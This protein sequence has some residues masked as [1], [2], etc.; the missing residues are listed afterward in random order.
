MGK[1]MDFV[2]AARAIDKVGDEIDRVRDE[3][4]SLGPPEETIDKARAAL[5]ALKERVAELEEAVAGRRAADSAVRTALEILV[6]VVGHND[7]TD[8]RTPN[9][10]VVALDRGRRALARVAAP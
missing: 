10:F 1:A 7:C 3:L 5:P 6:E 9:G 8:G 4:W 2:D